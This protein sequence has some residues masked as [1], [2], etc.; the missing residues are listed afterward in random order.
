MLQNNSSCW[1]NPNFCNNKEPQKPP[2]NFHPFGTEVEIKIK[3]HNEI[4]TD[5]NNQIFLKEIH[6]ICADCFIDNTC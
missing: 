6:N 2:I 1:T 4:I 5:I 3:C